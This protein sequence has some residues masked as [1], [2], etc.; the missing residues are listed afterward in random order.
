M[1]LGWQLYLKELEIIYGEM[2]EHIHLVEQGRFGLN[3]PLQA[4]GPA[5]PRVTIS[6]LLLNVGLDIM[7]VE[8]NR[9]MLAGANRLLTQAPSKTYCVHVIDLN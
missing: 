4:I 3:W 7:R 6:L 8:D 9:H 2:N 1:R 5:G